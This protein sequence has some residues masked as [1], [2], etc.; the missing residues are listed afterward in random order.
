MKK[1]DTYEKTRTMMYDFFIYI[2]EHPQ[3]RFWQALRNWCGADFII[4]ADYNNVK[5]TDKEGVVTATM[6]A[7]INRLWINE[8]DTFYED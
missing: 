7:D 6:L 8:K 1:D 5:I 2:Q 4:K 3:E